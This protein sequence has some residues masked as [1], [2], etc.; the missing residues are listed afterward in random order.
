MRTFSNVCNGGKLIRSDGFV[1]VGVR[2][3]WENY[4]ALN[5]LTPYHTI[6]RFSR[7]HCNTYVYQLPVT[8]PLPYEINI[9]LGFQHVEGI[10]TRT[11]KRRVTLLY[12]RCNL[13]RNDL[14][15]G[16]GLGPNLV[17][18]IYIV[19]VFIK[20]LFVMSFDYGA[21]VRSGLLQKIPSIY[22]YKV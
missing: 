19:L 13:M 4:V 10:P 5:P 7:T 14:G 16:N 1:F 2:V 6:Y 12:L 9:L 11:H 18:V 15:R 3:F 21:S 22:I 20:K 8:S 17:I